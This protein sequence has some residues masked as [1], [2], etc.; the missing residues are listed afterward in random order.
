MFL[1]FPQFICW[2]SYPNM[3]AFGGRAGREIIK[4]IWGLKDGPDSTRT[5]VPRRRLRDS[6]DL[7]LQE[8][9]GKAIQGYIRKVAIYKP[10]ESSHQEINRDTLI[11]DVQPSEWWENRFLLFKSHRLCYFFFLQT[12]SCPLVSGIFCGSQSTGLH[13]FLTL[14]FY[15]FFIAC[16]HFIFFI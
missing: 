16:M 9:K 12:L 2:S 3:T 5:G 4:V 10:G 7:S 6:R 1:L 11:L 13:A 8:Q 15:L 14:S